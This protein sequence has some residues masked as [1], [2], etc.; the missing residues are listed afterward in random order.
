MTNFCLSYHYLFQ[1]VSFAYLSLPL[2]EIPESSLSFLG[3]FSLGN[4]VNT[5]QTS[6]TSKLWAFLQ[7]KRS[8]LPLLV[9]IWAWKSTAEEETNPLSSPLPLTSWGG[10]VLP[11]AGMLQLCHNEDFGFFLVLCSFRELL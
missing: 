2:D 10:A 8:S 11:G 1:P 9:P 4:N 6:L 3:Y 7:L 5:T